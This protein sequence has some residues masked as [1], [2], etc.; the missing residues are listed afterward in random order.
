MGGLLSKQDYIQAPASAVGKN[1]DSAEPLALR[2]MTSP[3]TA[4]N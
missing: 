2:Y 3:V 1:W 4:A